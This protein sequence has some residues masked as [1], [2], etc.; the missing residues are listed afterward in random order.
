MNILVCIKRVPATAGKIELTADEQSI[1]ARYLGFTISP[2]EECAVEEA[3]RL[4]ERYGGSSTV[5][6]LGPAAAEE[7]L[8]DALAMGIDR[9]MLLE[10]DG[11]E[12]DP[13]ATAAAIVAAVRASGQRFDLLLLGSEAAD[14]GDYQVG[15]RVAHALDMPCVAG[16]KSL[17]IKDGRA[18]ARRETGGGWE[19]FEV[20]LPAVFTVKEGINLPRY[21]PL[22]GRLKAKKKAIERRQPGAAENALVKVRLALPPAQGSQVEILGQGPDV[23]ARAVD[24]LRSLG[25]V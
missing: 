15:V 24:V 2:H 3:V 12:W 7:Q 6:T 17:E 25:L 23:A 11:G 13:G 9:A 16:V 18:L 14:T 1:D 4:V 21:V 8:R 5:L 22:L 19:L 10:T 20:D